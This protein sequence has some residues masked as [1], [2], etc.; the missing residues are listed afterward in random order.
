MREYISNNQKTEEKTKVQ[1][2]SVAK[3]RVINKLDL[4]TNA[5]VVEDAM[6]FVSKTA[7]ETGESSFTI[8]KPSLIFQQHHL[9]LALA[10]LSQNKPGL[11]LGIYDRLSVGTLVL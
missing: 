3:E 6:K 2:L 5:I 8:L 11:V 7:K 4:L 10:L 1:A 9:M